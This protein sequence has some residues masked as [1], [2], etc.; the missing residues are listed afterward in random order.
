MK[1][2]RIPLVLL[3]EC[4]N[5]FVYIQMSESGSIL[6]ATYFLHMKVFPYKG[7][8]MNSTSSFV[9]HLCEEASTLKIKRLSPELRQKQDMIYF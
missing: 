5:T 3:S 9:P 2:I 8:N 6:H 1:V 4:L 7:D